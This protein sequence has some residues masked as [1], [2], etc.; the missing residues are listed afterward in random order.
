LLIP[1]AYVFILQYNFAPYIEKLA[2]DKNRVVLNDNKRNKIVEVMLKE[3]AGA[4]FAR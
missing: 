2:I 1:V 4:V 3:G